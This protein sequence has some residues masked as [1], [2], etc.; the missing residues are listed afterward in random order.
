MKEKIRKIRTKIEQGLESLMFSQETC[1]MRNRLREIGMYEVARNAEYDPLRRKGHEGYINLDDKL[2][3]IQEGELVDT[4]IT[5]EKERVK[6]GKLEPS[7]GGRFAPTSLPG[8]GTRRKY[9]L[10]GELLKEYD[11]TGYVLYN[12][13]IKI[14]LQFFLENPGSNYPDIINAE[15]KKFP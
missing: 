2:Y 15:E 4:G 1:K 11:E 10:N 12:A 7:Y 14:P 6:T 13:D 8:Y 3:L 9:F 5:V